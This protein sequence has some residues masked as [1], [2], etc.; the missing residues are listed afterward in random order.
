MLWL[1][2]DYRF[3]LHLA[4]GRPVAAFIL[5]LAFGFGWTPCIGPILGAIL[6]LAASTT[7]DAG[8]GVLL[9]AVYSAGLGLPFLIAGLLFHGF[10]TF[11]KQFRSYIRLFEILTGVLLALVGL[12]LMLNWFERLTGWLYRL[13]PLSS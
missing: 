6:A 8:R 3:H 11:F 13:F 1:Q 10:L 5:G 7:G 12:L 2:R 9:L 4:G